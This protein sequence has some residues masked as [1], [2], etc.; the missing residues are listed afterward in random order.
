MN[1]YVLIEGHRYETG[2]KKLKKVFTI[3]FY[4]NNGFL[5]YKLSTF[6]HKVKYTLSLFGVSE[7]Q[8]KV[9]LI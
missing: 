1:R 7:M 5:T 9:N 8:E 4:I 6:M 3:F 2:R